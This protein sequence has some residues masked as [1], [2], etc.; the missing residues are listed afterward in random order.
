MK[1][2]WSTQK[3]PSWQHVDCPGANGSGDFGC[4]R[5]KLADDPAPKGFNGVQLHV[6]LECTGCGHRELVCLWFRAEPK[7]KRAHPALLVE[8]LG[9]EVKQP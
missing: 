8:D 6:T 3:L 7:G 1:P 5:Y 9:M 2:F 4:S